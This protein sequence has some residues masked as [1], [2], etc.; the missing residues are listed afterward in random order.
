MNIAIGLARLGTGSL[1]LGCLSND[2]FGDRLSTL[3]ERERIERVPSIPIERH[4]RLAVIDQLDA[5]SPF[6]FYGDSPADV[7]LTTPDVDAALGR[8]EPTGLYVSS[9]MMTS[10][11]GRDSQ[12]YALNRAESLG[13]PI[14][15]DPNP[16]PAAWESREVMEEATRSLL[17]R[18]SLGKISVDD[19]DVLGWPIEP[20]ALVRWCSQ[21][22]D[23]AFVVTDG[24]RG[25][26]AYVDE[27]IV[28]A[29]AQA[30][31]SIDPTGAGDAFFAALIHRSQLD[32]RLS[33]DDLKFAN[34]AGAFATTRQGAVSGLG[35]RREIE[36]FLA[37]DR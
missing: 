26:W 27:R 33:E 23:G 1:F 11:T 10:R 4:T 7:A 30:V 2:G 25:S 21:R 9:L 22:F 31:G 13:L 37:G 3:L 36:R 24:E 20:A 15:C 35:S 6:R 5:E 32:D 18:C 12:N 19:A 29:P 34:A 28:H 16:R 14:Y 8:T 17:R